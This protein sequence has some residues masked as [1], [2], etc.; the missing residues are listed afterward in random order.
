MHWQMRI[1]SI[2]VRSFA[3][4]FTQPTE[5]PTDRTCSRGSRS[6]HYIPLRLQWKICRQRRRS[7]WNNTRKNVLEKLIGICN[8]HWIHILPQ[9]NIYKAVIKLLLFR[10]FLLWICWVFIFLLLLSNLQDEIRVLAF[11]QVKCCMRPN[12][13]TNVPIIKCK[14]VSKCLSQRETKII[15]VRGRS[16]R[17]LILKLIV[18][19]CATKSQIKLTQVI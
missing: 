17:C 19:I 6:F 11:I 14:S 2:G 1:I 10:R 7:I 18:F 12:A 3:R 8:L 16:E 15:R 13:K 5:Q 4:I 9:R